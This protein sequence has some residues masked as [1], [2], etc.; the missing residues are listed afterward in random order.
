[1][2]KWE[3]Y[4]TPFQMNDPREESSNGALIYTKFE[5]GNIVYTGIFLFSGNLPR[6]PGANQVIYHLIE[7]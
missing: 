2:V 6:V 1:V 4:E 3:R 7:E 5:K